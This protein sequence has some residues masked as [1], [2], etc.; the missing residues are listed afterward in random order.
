MWYVSG[1]EKNPQIPSP[2]SFVQVFFRE[3]ERRAYLCN[4]IYALIHAYTQVRGHLSAADPVV[5]VPLLV[6]DV[7]TLEAWETL[8]DLK[9]SAVLRFEK[10]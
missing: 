6:L 4:Y 5:G 9:G 7:R 1:F 2:I 8:L 10:T 3:R